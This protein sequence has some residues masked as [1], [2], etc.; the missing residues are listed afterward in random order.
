MTTLKLWQHLRNLPLILSLSLLCSA[1]PVHSTEL[2][3]DN[4]KDSISS[5]VWFIEHFSPYCGHCRAFAPTWEEL[6]QKNSEGGEDPTG[7]KL[8][9]VNCAVHGDL[10][11]TNGVKGYPQMNIYKDGEF[12]ETF[13]GARELPRLTEFLKRHA[14]VAPTEEPELEE[15]ELETPGTNPNPT[16]N[17]IVLDDS[18]FD[19]VLSEG[20][21]F[22]KFY[23][24]W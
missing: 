11:S 12:V 13:K 16:G 2:T 15:T 21:A 10:C 4:F 1:L 23:A 18:N 7:V 8:A 5:G 24:P 9:Q 14:P 20:P 22:V 3:P 6:V 17:V 19:N